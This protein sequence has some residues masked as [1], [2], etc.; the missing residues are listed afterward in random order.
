[1]NPL[2]LNFLLKT[3]DKTCHILKYILIP[4]I[5]LSIITLISA[6]PSLWVTSSIHHFYVELFGAI[7]AGILAFYY[8][9]R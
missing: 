1:M 7:L 8:I 3:N 4:S 6:N 2:P 5:S 9:S